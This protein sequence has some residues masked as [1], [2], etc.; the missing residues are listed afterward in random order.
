MKMKK[1]NI[2]ILIIFKVFVISCKQEVFEKEN[3]NPLDYTKLVLIEDLVHLYE[4]DNE[5]LFASPLYIEAVINGITNESLHIQDDSG[6][7]LKV[8]T[9]NTEKYNTHDIIRIK[10]GGMLLN[11]NNYHFILDNP[12]EITNIGQGSDNTSSIS[13]SSLVEDIH[14]FTSKVVH[15]NEDELNFSTKKEKKDISSYLIE[16]SVTQDLKL[17]VNVPN[18]LDY[19]MPMSISSVTGFIVYEDE[20]IYINIRAK[21]DV[22]E[23]YI[24]PSMME[25]IIQNS[26]FVQSV[27]KSTEEEIAPGVKMSS[28]SYIN[29]ESGELASCTIL[30]AD[31]NNSKV[32]IEGGSPNDETSPPYATLQNLSTMATGKN[33]YYKDTKWRVLAAVTGDLH[34]GA[35]PT[36]VVRGP[37]I[38]YGEI[39]STEYWDPTHYF[40]GIK[41][42]QT[43]PVMGNKAEFDAMKN[44]LEHVVGG[45][46]LLKDGEIPNL[47][48]NRDAR[49]AIGYSSNNRVYLFVGN[50]RYPDAGA[51]YTRREIAEVFQALGC[52]GGLYLMEGGASVG[53][54]E[55]KDSSEYHTFSRTHASNINHNPPLAS[56]WMIVTERD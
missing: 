3:Q 30:E 11:K 28:M 6:I 37:V 8:L 15:I 32:R 56:S 10:T 42:D 17:W 25:K 48:G 4:V 22:Q 18:G 2:L 38:R 47:E 27:N 39:L 20:N 44:D 53:I 14:T 33:D 12:K 46:V 9:T 21:N 51:G 1:I 31:L 50:G 7:G 45:I 34:Q 13:L 5:K 36:Y 29:K 40:L 35:A 52:E 23:V 41:K 16:Q 26:S 43:T 54:V 55:D 49:A 24:E 19:D